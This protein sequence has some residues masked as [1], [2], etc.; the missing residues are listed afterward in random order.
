M[1][2][3]TSHTL[4]AVLAARDLGTTVVQY[5]CARLTLAGA[6]GNV[7]VGT[8]PAGA[9]I[10]SVTT[11]VVTAFSG[12]VPVFNVGTASGGAQVAA[13]IAITAGSLNTVPIAALVMPLAANTDI[14]AGT[15]GSAT[16]G[17]AIIA[18]MFIKPLN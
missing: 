18:V 13:A 7:K 5:V 4:N 3:P 10:T 8:I 1:P 6:D 14:W 17:D 9:M 2:S 15:T 11:K 16:A 12:G